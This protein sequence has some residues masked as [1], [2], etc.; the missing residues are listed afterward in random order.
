MLL[1]NSAERLAPQISIVSTILYKQF[2]AC[3][4][5]LKN[6]SK[7]LALVTELN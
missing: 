3:I 4:Y 2:F 1:L 7:I 6:M 5:K